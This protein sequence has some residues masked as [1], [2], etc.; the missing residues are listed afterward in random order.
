[1]WGSRRA[2]ARVGTGTLFDPVPGVLD[3][4]VDAINGVVLCSQ[5]TGL[6]TRSVGGQGLGS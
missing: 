6:E 4:I 3:E 2:G 5:M 1:M